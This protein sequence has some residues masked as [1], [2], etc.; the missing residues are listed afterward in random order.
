LEDHPAGWKKTHRALDLIGVRWNVDEIA[1]RIDVSPVWVRNTA[2]ALLYIYHYGRNK[3]TAG[4]IAEEYGI[5]EVRVEYL[6]WINV[7][8]TAL[9]PT[10]EVLLLWLQDYPPRN[11]SPKF[12]ALVRREQIYEKCKK[13]G[14]K[15]PWEYQENMPRPF[16]AIP[17]D[18]ADKFYNPADSVNE[19]A[20]LVSLGLFQELKFPRN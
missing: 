8:F 14:R 15:P 12:Q 4:E 18:I 3:S 11:Q 6:L 5:E 7:H 17:R 16:V 2:V 13:E 19:I 9:P 1:Q 20:G 10:R